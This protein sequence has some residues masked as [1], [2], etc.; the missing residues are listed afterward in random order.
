[1]EAWA[2]AIASAAPGHT[3]PHLVL[4]ACAEQRGDAES[5]EARVGDVLRVDPDDPLALYDAAWCAEDRGE[6][7][8]G[9]S[10]LRR[11][12]VDHDDAQLQRLEAYALPGPAFAGRNEPCPCGSG[13]K[14]KVCC[15]QRNGYPLAD[16]VFWLLA[17]AGEFLLRPGQRGLVD[18]VAVAR[19]GGDPDDPRRVE[20]ATHDPMVTDLA[21]FE[22]GLL[23]RFCDERG[24]LLPADE[25]ELA[26]SWLGAPMGLHEVAGVAPGH[27]LTLRNLSTGAH[28]EV[29]DVSGSTQVTEGVLLL[30]R[31]LPVG[32][33][34]VLA[35]AAMEVPF[36][37]RDALLSVLD[38]EPDAVGIAAWLAAA[39]A[40]ARLTTT[41]G[42]PMVACSLRLRVDDPHAAARALDAILDG[43]DGWWARHGERQHGRVLL[44]EVTIGGDIVEVRAS[45]E[46]R[47]E[48][49]IAELAVALPRAELVDEERVPGPSG[50]AVGPPSGGAPVRTQALDT[51]VAEADE[52]VAA[53]IA[54][55]EERWVDES[56]PA[57]GGST[58]RQAAADPTRRDDLERL[59][60]Q[61]AQFAES[62]GDALPGGSVTFDA[63][64]LR[65]LLGL[66]A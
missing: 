8:R 35:P 47:F 61:F 39:Q 38:G 57:L 58:P 46:P 63:A 29:R 52:A 22:G 53:F 54:E 32:E 3:G 60:A 43:G 23:G 18:V 59:L 2:T 20:V 33:S 31:P 5:A 51:L 50:H 19:S 56:I 55:A 11:A 37:V 1:V 45:S 28:V 65:R 9:V 62:Q 64:R 7:A 66:D 14:Y 49:L 27:G 24:P 36:T 15:A 30:A 4:A 17:K 25:L 10:L 44:G 26:R 13:R 6:A 48:A 41:D 12:G 34:H 40:P 42:D 21:L 16:R